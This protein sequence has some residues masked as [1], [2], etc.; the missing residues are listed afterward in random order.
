MF[1]VRRSSVSF[2]I[3]LATLLATGKLFSLS[4]GLKPKIPLHPYVRIN[5]TSANLDTQPVAESI[6]PYPEN[7]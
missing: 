5:P 3:K 2:L 4:A 7:R 6:E 1:D